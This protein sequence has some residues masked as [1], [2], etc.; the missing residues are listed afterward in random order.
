M[1][2]I[3]NTNSHKLIEL[4]ILFDRDLNSFGGFNV[5]SFVCYFIKEKF[6]K[7]FFGLVS[8]ESFR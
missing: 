1:L 5:K 3:V 7:L 4:D 6:F 8:V 2:T